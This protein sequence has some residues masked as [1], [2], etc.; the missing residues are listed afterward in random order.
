MRRREEGAGRGTERDLGGGGGGVG[1]ERGREARRE[2]G[3]FRGK[4]A[5]RT[6]L[7]TQVGNFMKNKNLFTAQLCGLCAAAAVERRAAGGRCEKCCG[8]ANTRA[9]PAGAQFGAAVPAV[10]FAKLNYF[11]A[12]LQYFLFLLKYTIFSSIAR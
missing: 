2:I 5:R 8:H 7:E 3:K 12:N 1:T 4:Y 11:S 10:L 9:R 6:A